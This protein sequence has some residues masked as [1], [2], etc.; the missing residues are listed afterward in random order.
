MT[1]SACSNQTELLGSLGSN[2]YNASS[3][4]NGQDPY[5][6]YANSGSYWRPS[7]TANQ[8]IQVRK[9]QNNKNNYATT[10][11]PTPTTTTTT[12]TTQWL[13]SGVEYNIYK[14]N[15]LSNLGVA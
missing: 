5:K 14:W 3:V 13:G 11:T 7:R 6:V 9:H 4:Y 10:T 15:M 8:W 12:T 2:R 1:I